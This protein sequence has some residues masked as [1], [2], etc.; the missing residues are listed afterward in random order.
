MGAGEKEKGDL[1]PRDHGAQTIQQR[2]V[3]QFFGF[4]VQRTL[5]FPLLSQ[6]L[7]ILQP[8]GKLGVRKMRS[9]SVS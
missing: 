6:S 2:R 7:V 5:L 8:K 3:I 1:L 9:I 4:N